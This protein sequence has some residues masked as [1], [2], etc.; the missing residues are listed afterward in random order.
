V[1][2]A[3]WLVPALPLAGA[4]VNLVVGRR[5]REWSGWLAS[6]VVAAAFVVAL[7]ALAQLVSF[8]PADRLSISHLYEWITVGSFHVGINFRVDPLSMTMILVV[9]G[10]GTLIHVYAIGYMHGDERFSRFFVYMNLFVFFML[11]L[12]LADNFLLMYLGWEG[13]GLCSYLLIGF[14]FE[15][16]DAARAAKKAFIVTRIGDTAMLVGIALIFVTFHSLDFGRVLH[17]AAGAVSTGT[18][19]AIALLLLAGAVGKS[20]QLPLHVWL[21]DAMEGPTPVS[22]LIHAATMVT[23]GVYLVVRT[24]V[25]FEDSGVALTV[26]LIVGLATA[27]YAATAALGQDDIKRVLAYSTISQLGFMF[28][29]VGLKAYAAAIFLL[30]THALYKALMF[31]SAGSVMHGMHNETDLKKMG[32][33]WTLMPATATAFSIGALALAGV[34]PF[35]GFFSKDEIIAAADQTGHYVAY[36]LALLA[37]FLSALYIARLVFLAFF[38]KRRS[39]EPAHESPPIMT[40]PLA[41]LSVG[42]VAGGLLGLT[43]AGGTIAR[44]LTPVVGAPAEPTS[45]LSEVQLTLIS[46]AIAVAGIGVAYLFY[47]SGRIDWLARRERNEDLHRFLEKGWY[48]DAAYAEA[49]EGPG[50]GSARFL[51]F[52]VDRKVI[53]GAVNGVGEVFRWLASVGRRIQ[54][55]FVRNYAL[56]FLLGAV[57]LLVYVG[58]RR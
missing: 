57:V 29:A 34:P 56:G 42:A 13:V 1:L 5:L 44:F 55:G 41:L 58:A 30:V 16:P 33:L 8:S 54:T 6:A 53:D 45:G 47:A 27:L 22:A 36:V 18:V 48:I 51:A 21:P 10:V 38:G 23:A 4:I 52:V 43:A 28:F 19:T 9:T 50:K 35:A 12:V 11:T 26:V 3:I 14:W 24:H 37:A 31:L 20:A 39:D 40:L 15:R 25:L 46:V 32:G 7:I 2:K 49:V 17:G